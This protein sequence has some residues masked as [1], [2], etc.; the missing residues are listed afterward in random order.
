MSD[1]NEEFLEDTIPSL[2]EDWKNK[3]KVSDLLSDFNNA[4]SNKDTQVAIIDDWLAQLNVTGAYKP[5]QQMGRSSVQPKLIRKQAEWRYSALSEPFLNDENIFSIAPKTWQDRE[6]AR[7]NEAILN[8]QFNNQ[9]DKVKLIDTMVRTA[10]NEGTVIFRTSWCLEETKVTENVPVF[11]Y[12][13]ATG[14]SI[15]L[16]NQAVQMYQMNPSILDTMPEVLAESVRYSVAN[17]RPILAI[18]NGYEEQEVI[19]TVKNQPEVTICDYHNVT[20][21]PT[22]NGNLDEAKFVIHSFESSRSDLEKYGIYSNLE[23]IKE[24]SSTSTSSDHYSSET[25]FTFSDKARKKIV[26]YEYWGYWDIDGS[27]V[28]TPIVASWVDDVMIRLEKNP[29]PDGKLPFVVVP[30]LPVKDSVYGE[31]DAELLSDNQKLI[32]ALI[33]GMIDAMARSANGQRGMSKNLLDPLN[34]RKF[35]MGEDYKYNPGTNPQVDIIEHKYP[36]LPASTYNML[37]MFNL[38]ADALSGVKS[39]SQGLTGD[40]LGTT[41]AGVQGVIGASGKR[42]LGILRRLAN[43][44]T[45]VAKKILAMN[46]VWLSDEEV[47]RITDEE[48]VQI[49][50]DNL[51]GSFDIKLSISN[52]ETDAI[53][54]QELS[55][56]LQTMG[57]S[58]PFDMTKLI[59]GEIAKLR[60]MPDLSKMISKYNPEPS[61]QAQLEM[62]IKQLE[63]QELQM[64]IAKL[65]AEIQLMPYEAQTEVAKARKANTEADLNTLDF[66]EQETGVKQERELELMQAQAKG[67]TQRDIVKTFLDTNKQG[68]Q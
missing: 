63:A 2:Q 40:S 36:E 12:V 9:L 16:I 4:K 61:P 15:D 32:G 49:N 48:F 39:F 66:V 20:I 5:K 51:V 68:N 44:L 27:G 28:T 6:A 31:A 34:E 52:A 22:C 21:D 67:N 24:D 3:P 54:A 65:Q 55:F 58:L 53:K 10:V 17:N 13:E 11:Q 47:I 25:S 41:A 62:Q 38:E 29:Y 56:M 23:Y 19:K 43:G 45:E 26:V 50:R 33:R 37:Q 1:I 7:Q 42:E 60:G 64:R 30:Y 18:I 35:K 59:L 57:Q 14:E 46:S 8:Y